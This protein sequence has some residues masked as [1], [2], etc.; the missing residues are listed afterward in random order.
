M[1][2]L[3]TVPQSCPFGSKGLIGISFFSFYSLSYGTLHR[4]PRVSPKLP[5]QFKEWVIPP[6]VAVGMS[7][8]YQHRD[9]NIFPQPDKF[10]PERWLK[11]VTPAMKK[12]YI[13]FSKGSRHCLGMK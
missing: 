9:P 12:N 4:R 1:L 3:F 7:A 6:G 2:S 5:L 11:D 8:Y 10:V 13:P